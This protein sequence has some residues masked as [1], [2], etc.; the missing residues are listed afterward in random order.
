MRASTP[1]SLSISDIPRISY[2]KYSMGA[3]KDAPQKP[4]HKPAKRLCFGKDEQ[5]NGRDLPLAAGRGIWSLRGRC[6]KGVRST[7]NATE[8]RTTE[9]LVF[10]RVSAISRPAP[11]FCILFSGKTEKSMSPK[12]Q[13]R[14]CRNNG[15]AVNPEKSSA[16]AARIECHPSGVTKAPPLRAALFI[17][18][19]SAAEA[20]RDQSAS[21]HRPGT[22]SRGRRARPSSLPRAC[23]SAP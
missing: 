11:L 15:T 3:N 22:H 8:I 14:C 6:P 17:S 1:T 2:V 4:K 5:R 7:E 9:R 19:P 12:A 16:P 13:L 23:G 18:F 10:P 21:D 20:Y